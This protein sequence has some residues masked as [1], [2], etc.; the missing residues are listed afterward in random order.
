[1]KPARC[2]CLLQPAHYS[3]VACQLPHLA[4]PPADC[5]TLPACPP[6]ELHTGLRF[7]NT[8]P[9]RPEDAGHCCTAS[10]EP[11]NQIL[12]QPARTVGQGIYQVTE[13]AVG[14]QNQTGGGSPQDK[15]AGG[16]TGRQI[17]IRRHART[18]S[19]PPAAR[20]QSRGMHPAA[21]YL[22]IPVQKATRQIKHFSTIQLFD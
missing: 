2:H 5:N 8:Y 19:I 20:S 6:H 18:G 15:R 1:M 11:D 9:M 7:R 17:H 13:R 22:P 12:R 16:H 4:P 10:R 3:P 21:T 14:T